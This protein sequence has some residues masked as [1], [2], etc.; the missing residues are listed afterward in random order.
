MFMLVLSIY[1]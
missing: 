1:S